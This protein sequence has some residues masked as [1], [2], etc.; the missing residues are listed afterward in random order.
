MKLIIVD[1]DGTLLNSDKKVSEFTQRIFSKIHQNKNY[2]VIIATGRSI[3]RS[4]KY[5]EIINADGII[6]LNG[7]KNFLNNTMISEYIINENKISNL[8]NEILNVKDVYLNITY[9]DYI[10]TNNKAICNNNFIIYTNFEYI[11]IKEIQKMTININTLNQKN[12]ITKLD[13]DKY[14]CK[15]IYNHDPYY[16]TI[17]NKKVS[18]LNGLLDIC[19]ILNLG[20]DSTIVFGDDYND[21][22]ILSSAGYSIA[23][24][25]ALQ[26]IKKL[27]K[28]ICLSN[29]NDGVANWINNNLF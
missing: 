19:K 21:F 2:K 6:S 29:D 13:F 8:I 11:N 12:I 4:S 24:E 7:A 9:P 27:A 14:N 28:E 3:M 25:N 17:L 10:L 15:L 16:F 20:L 18:K 1:L 26:D 23:V 22:D 5:M